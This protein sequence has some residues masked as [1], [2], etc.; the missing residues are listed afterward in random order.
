MANVTQDLRYAIRFL[1][2]RPVVSLLAVLCLSIGIGATT[3]IFSPVDLF[4]I[5]PFP[6]P[7]ADRL[8]LPEAADL[9]RGGDEMPLS[10]PDF[11]D[12]RAQS[13][14][15]DIA[16]YAD[17]SFNLSGIERPERLQ[18][19]QVSANFLKVL[20]V[21]PELGRDFLPEEERPGT[22]HPV[23]LSHELWETRFDA[24]PRV[25][26]QSIKLDGTPYTVVGAMPPRFG[27]PFQTAQLWTPLVLSGTESRGSHWL[28]AVARL[29]P[30]ATLQQARA[31]LA[32]MTLQLEQAYP[33]T[34]QHLGAV[35]VS[36]RDGIYG[37]QFRF[38]SGI[39]S[40]AVAFLLLIAAANVANLLLAQ[41]AGRDRE[42][43]I[44]TALGA[45]RGR[46]V[47]QLL[48][49]SL[50]LGLAAGGVALGFAWAGIKGLL[51]VMP[52]WFP[53]VN[54]MR[55]DG[56]VLAFGAVV[57]IVA[58][59][60]AGLGPA[61]HATRQSVRESLQEGGRGSSLGRRG[62]RLRAAFVTAEIALA[63]ALVA[64]AGLLAKG[65]ATLRSAPLGFRPSNLLTLALTLPTSKYPQDADVSRFRDQ[66]LPRIAG[67]PGVHAV[68]AGSGI[69]TMNGNG[70]YYGVEGEDTPEGNRPIVGYRSVTPGY[71]TT[72]GAT[73]QGGRAFTAA[74]RVDAPLVAVVNEAFARRHWPNGTALGHR[75]VLRSG[76]RTIVGVVSDIREY[77]P[78]TSPQPALVYF[79][80]AQLP[81]RAMA[82]AIRTDGDPV[83]LAGPVRAAVLALDADQPVFDVMT[84]DARI[85]A[86]TQGDG[87][88][89]RIMLVLAAVALA[90]ALV[91]V[92][93][94]VSYSVSQRTPEIGIRMALGAAR[95]DVVTMVV[96]QSARVVALGSVIGVALAL[97]LGRGLSIFLFGVS[98]FD[99]TTLTLVP[100][101]LALAALL[102][103]YVPARRAS[104]VDPLRALR[105]E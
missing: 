16:A 78:S 30:G 18:G 43:A 88:V 103:S 83:V 24:D 17:L 79:P 22:A 40:V 4:M 80:A 23:I 1:L 89:A 60:I 10:A 8:V 55:L 63:I 50:I 32:A 58:A 34:N 41:A 19:M 72:L 36:V 70:A 54:E 26:G 64:A 91:G 52:S 96:G 38:G 77:G 12:F 95:G 97:A 93:G 56:R 42:I 99:P 85:S 20:Q 29:R 46:V 75:I 35:V 66:L 76:T 11:V 71:F 13:K 5:R 9:S 87:V 3:A 44:R 69:P 82:V 73:L 105:A 53:R 51:L 84:M 100:L 101:S 68:A 47:R 57:S 81:T 67:L 2:H 25:L 65:F 28:G 102:A 98:P 62:G 104:R 90:L 14:T 39:S 48:T 27:F 37:P 33:E 45:G 61:L 49:E 94:V 92:Y 59:G 15:L 6:Y 7:R 74:D 31:E 86:Q 21:A